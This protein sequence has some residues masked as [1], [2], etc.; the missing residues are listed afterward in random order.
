MHFVK[1]C[2][3]IDRVFAGLPQRFNIISVLKIELIIYMEQVL[4]QLSSLVHKFL[5]ISLNFSGL[6][7]SG[8][9]KENYKQLII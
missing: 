2:V 5:S 7:S 6:V 8:Y 1:Y 9:E 4:H 3:H